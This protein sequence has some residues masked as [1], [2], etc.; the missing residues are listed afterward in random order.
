MTT[1]ID[2]HEK[3]AEI[4]SR[5]DRLPRVRLALLP[6]P[7]HE[8]PRL[9]EAIGVGRLFFKRDDLTGLA[10]GGNKTRNLEFRM[11]DAVEQGA[12]V[13]VAGLEVHSNSARQVTAAAN[14]LGMSPILLLRTD[15][16][17]AWQGNVLVDR[18][19]GADIR[20][21]ETTDKAVMDRALANV[22][23]E[24]RQLGKKPFV[25]NHN[26]SFAMGSALAYV[27]CTLEIVEQSDAAGIEPTHLYMASGNKGHAGLLLAKE[28]LG[29]RFQPVAISQHYAD[30]RVSGALDGVRAAAAALGYE[31]HLTEADVES[32]DDFVETKYGAPSQRGLEAI[33]LAARTEGLLLDPIY[34]GKALAGL[35]EHARTG[36]VGPESTVVFVHTGGQ[37]ALFSFADALLDAFP[38]AEDARI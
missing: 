18:V 32:Y 35:I 24:Q 2:Q 1:A 29:A 17:V 19:L 4:R 23:E 3:I 15:G 38:L 7:F 6:T 5:F 28:L 26:P 12:D 21:I 14:L 25:M 9:A 34:T 31:T 37:P 33:A 20:F 8:A 11:A 36:K 16:P 30:D 27:L 13:F 10:F 22:A